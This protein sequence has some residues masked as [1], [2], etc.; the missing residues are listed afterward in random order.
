MKTHINADTKRLIKAAVKARMALQNLPNLFTGS[1]L[2]PNYQIIMDI[3]AELD[4]AVS[5]FKED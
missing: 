4:S 5:P 3:I 2:P 1:I